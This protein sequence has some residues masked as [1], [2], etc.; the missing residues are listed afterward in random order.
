MFVLNPIYRIF[1]AIADKD[2]TQIQKIIKSLN[3]EIP[4]R[5]LNLDGNRVTTNAA[6]IL[7]RW[8]PLAP[9]ILTMVV[10]KLPNPIEAQQQRIPVLWK[11]FPQNVPVM[12]IDTSSGNDTGG[13][14]S[15]SELYNSQQR[16][17]ESMRNCSTSDDADV[18]V[19]VS[20][21]FSVPNEALIGI[22]KPGEKQEITVDRDGISFVGM[23]RIF[24]G[25]LRLGRKVH[26]L[27]PKYSPLKPTKHITTIS[28]D[29]LFL[30]MGRSLESLTSVPAGNVFGIG[31]IE[32]QIL[33]TA[34]ISNNLACVS[35]DQMQKFAAPIVRVAVEAENSSEI[36]KLREGLRLLNVAD[37]GCEVVVQ[38]TGE[39]IVAASGELH[40][41][42]CL[43]DLQ[44]SY[45]KINIKVSAPLLSFKET[46]TN[47]LHRDL[48]LK[49]E[50][51]RTAIAAEGNG[52]EGNSSGSDN[53]EKSEV[54]KEKILK[55]K[56][57][58]IVTTK[59]KDESCVIRLVAKQLPKNIT[60]WLEQNSIRLEAFIRARKARANL[61]DP[62][63]LEFQQEL[64]KEFEKAGNKWL[65]K[66]NHIWAFGPHNY[67]PNILINSI[68]DYVNS[69]YWKSIMSLDGI[70]LPE[71]EKQVPLNQRH[72]ILKQIDNSIMTGF[73]I[74][75]ESG[76]LCQEPITGVCFEILSLEIDTTVDRETLSTLCGPLTGQIIASVKSACHE[77]F[78][79]RSQRIVEA[80]YECFVQVYGADNLGKVYHVL[81]RRRSKILKEDI[82][83][84]SQ[85]YEITAYMPAAESFGFADELFT[86]T[87]G[88]AHGQLVFSHWEILDQDPDFIPTTED[89]IEESGYNIATLGNNIARTYID[90]V[91]KRKGLP[92]KEKIVKNPNQQRTLS[93]KK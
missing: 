49:I 17:F 36:S 86:K 42:R 81:A 87:S 34:T 79:R 59:T 22:S 89:E 82:K 85:I 64:R 52:A 30:L 35:F 37:P 74:A 80:L 48:L 12:N 50:Q 90:D 56:Q 18:V 71:N 70:E 69:D 39:H 14:L 84:G 15:F 10:E 16:I 6:S 67:G 26:I 88:T 53:E 91:R 27:G 19:F 13:E 21:V 72:V 93:K 40:L 60:N 75:V 28:V 9:A 68:K 54:V 58:V 32:N 62:V 1:S 3:L 77:A 45:A 20:K 11:I 61:N 57:A 65:R 47:E 25:R 73:G 33:K 43:S 4:A 78:K 29:K 83:E 23:A 92:V 55:L 44:Q 41:K 24:S 51:E 76:P 7:C 31:G 63:F 8:L 2:L 38:N 5:E 46:I 66:F